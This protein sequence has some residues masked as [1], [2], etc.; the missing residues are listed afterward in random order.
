MLKKIAD[1][2]GDAEFSESSTLKEDTYI[3]REA[4]LPGSS[5]LKEEKDTVGEAEL[6]GSSI[7]KEEKDIVGE[8]EL[9]GSSILKEEKDIVGETEL[10]GSSILKEENDIV[11]ETEIPASVTLK[12]EKD[13][14]GEAELPRSSTLKEE[15][16]IVGEAELPGSITLKEEVDIVGVASND[17]LSSL[18]ALKSKNTCLEELENGTGGSAIHSLLNRSVGLEE[19]QQV[20]R[21]SCSLLAQAALG[22]VSKAAWEA[23]S[24]DSAKILGNGCRESLEI[25]NNS[26]EVI[27]EGFRL[28]RSKSLSL[29]SEQVADELVQVRRVRSESDLRLLETDL[30]GISSAGDL[31]LS[32][33]KDTSPEPST[34]TITSADG[35]VVLHTPRRGSPPPL[36]PQE[37]LTQTLQQPIILE[38]D[39][40]E[41]PLVLGMV[42]FEQVTDNTQGDTPVEKPDPSPAKK[43][44]GALITA[45]GGWNLWPFPLRRPRNPE[46]NGSAPVLSREALIVAGKAA[47]D[48][49]LVN[50]LVS[51]RDYYLRS[52]KN[53]VRSF[54]PTSQML[55]TMNLKEGS[56]RITF[57]FYTRVL[58]RQQVCGIHFI[59]SSDL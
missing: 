49:A 18:A 31:R 40:S 38:G 12:E 52:R 36:I 56:N 46:I 14:V 42:A 55:S 13:I 11:G 53:K 16:D 5:T 50:N 23:G 47:V 48:S 57:T 25:V 8:T 44:V 2:E 4:E 24:E 17:L 35:V 28:R 32:R 29:G 59:T 54:L 7:L 3:T 20:G 22:A 27:A 58:G 30:E 19:S 26:G 39:G 1:I 9:P 45:S 37:D 34:L 21:P 6:P 10:P 43:E 41:K 51:E 33:I 15:K